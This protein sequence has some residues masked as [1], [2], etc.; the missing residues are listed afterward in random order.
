MSRR[1]GANDKLG[2][3]GAKLADDPALDRIRTLGLGSATRVSEFLG[4]LFI[5]DP[6]RFGTQR[7]PAVVRDV[8]AIRWQ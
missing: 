2:K 6:Q 4:H 1:N 8:S 7:A 3:L 5:F